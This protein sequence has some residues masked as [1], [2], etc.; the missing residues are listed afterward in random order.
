MLGMAGGAVT[1]NTFTSKCILGHRCQIVLDIFLVRQDKLC[2]DPNKR[3]L[4]R[5]GFSPPG[6]NPSL[7]SLHCKDNAERHAQAPRVCM[8]S[9]SGQLSPAALIETPFSFAIVSLTESYGQLICCQ[10]AT[11]SAVLYL[12]QCLGK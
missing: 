3:V 1:Q 2:C 8:R 10:A 5:L 11:M 12:A 9:S 4:P 7:V 6:V